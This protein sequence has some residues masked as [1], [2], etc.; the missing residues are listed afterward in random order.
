[1][2]AVMN[3]P[4]YGSVEYYRDYFADIIGDVSGSDDIEQN[5]KVICNIMAGLRMAIKESILY[6]DVS[7]ESY[8]ELLDE[9][10]TDFKESLLHIL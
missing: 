4:P 10:D 7:A 5:R 2:I 3:K 9:L 8:R 1:L 6:H